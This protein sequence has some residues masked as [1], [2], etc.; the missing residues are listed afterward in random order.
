M[1]KIKKT[2]TL[3]LAICMIFG[4]MN[5]VAYAEEAEEHPVGSYENMHQ[6][7]VGETIRFTI[8]PGEEAYIQVSGGTNVEAT[9]FSMQDTWFAQY[10]FNQ[11]SM[12]LNDDE[13]YESKFSMSL[14]DKD[15]FFMK[16]QSETSAVSI[17][18][19]ISGGEV[20]QNDGSSMD[21]AIE[22]TL[23]NGFN[24][25]SAFGQADIA[26]NSEGMYYYV[27][28]PIDG[29]ISLNMSSYLDNG[30]MYSLSN[31][32]NSTSTD[33]H[34]S[35]DEASAILNYAGNYFKGDVAEIY[36]RSPLT[37]L[38]HMADFAAMYLEENPYKIN[39]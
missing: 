23:E 4:L 14:E 27:T 33:I 20:S 17:F 19:T 11:A 9:V 12:E 13:M 15:F 24:G 32:T 10:T 5:V 1:K 30:W 8:M 28:A 35:N 7:T 26:E 39:E 34:L 29:Y 16:N 37:S 21:K 6:A 3:I 36:N 18:V 2:M 22:L 38:L 31:V 25:I